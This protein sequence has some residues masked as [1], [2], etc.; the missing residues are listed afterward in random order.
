MLNQKTKFT[1]QLS[2]K[3]PLE[4]FR[5][6]N[7]APFGSEPS[8]I[9]PAFGIVLKTNKL[10]RFIIQKGRVLDLQNKLCYPPTSNVR[11]KSAAMFF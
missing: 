2:S 11:G 5:Q 6:P 1:P 8:D 3:P 10:K 4:N 7:M 9:K